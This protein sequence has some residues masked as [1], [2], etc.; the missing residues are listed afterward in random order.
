MA[1]ESPR[2]TADMIEATEFP[3]LAQKYHVAGVPRTIIN[4]TVAIEGAVPEETFLDHILKLNHPEE[5]AS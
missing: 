3:H 4:E 5:E 1:I 2:I